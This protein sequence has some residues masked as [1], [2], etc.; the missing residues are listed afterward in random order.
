MQSRWSVIFTSKHLISKIVVRNGVF[1]YCNA[2]L[3]IMNELFTE[4]KKKKEKENIYIITYSRIGVFKGA[5]KLQPK[6]IFVSATK[7]NENTTN[8]LNC[9]F[10]K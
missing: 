2:L 1:F 4:K 10:S 9:H 7:I 8:I 5:T 6:I 3:S